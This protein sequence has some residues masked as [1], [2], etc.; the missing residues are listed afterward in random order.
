MSTTTAPPLAARPGLPPRGPLA[1]LDHRDRARGLPHA[2]R[3]EQGVV[4]YAA[5]QVRAALCRR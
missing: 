1:I 5:E 4:V 2:E 3:V